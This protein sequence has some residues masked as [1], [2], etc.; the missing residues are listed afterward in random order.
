M[1]NR[2]N[3]LPIAPEKYNSFLNYDHLISSS[4]KLKGKEK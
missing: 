2:D 1:Q 4:K 3:A